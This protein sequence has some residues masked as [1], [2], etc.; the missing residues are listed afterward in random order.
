MD[1]SNV[2]NDLEQPGNSSPWASTS[3]QVDRST[4]SQAP[5]DNYS[6]PVPIRQQSPGPQGN[7]SSIANKFPPVST[8]LPSN[9]AALTPADDDSNSPDLSEQLQS[10]QLG[11]PDYL[12]DHEPSPYQQQQARQA[13]QY[14]A[15]QQRHSA[16]R[17]Q[18]GQRPQRPIPAYKLQAKITALERTGRKDPVLRFDVHVRHRLCSMGS[19]PLTIP[20]RI[21]QSSVPHN[22]VTSGVRTRNL[23]SSPSILSLLIL[24]HLFLLYPRV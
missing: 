19:L 11:D 2:S 4:F 14:A 10:A 23:S 3:P 8:D 22:S 6:S 13:Q 5:S 9:S 7:G 12:G 20:R 17:Y 15:Q 16:A 24:K 18:T 21:S 1:Y